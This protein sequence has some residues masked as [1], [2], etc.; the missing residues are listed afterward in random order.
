MSQ[1]N[2]DYI[3]HAQCARMV[4]MQSQSVIYHAQIAHGYRWHINE[5]LHGRFLVNVAVIT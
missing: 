3:Y 1:E 5:E 2:N 4:H